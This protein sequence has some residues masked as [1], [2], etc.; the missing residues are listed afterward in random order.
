M[1]EKSES[2][3]SFSE[4]M[5]RMKR[6]V[7]QLVGGLDVQSVTRRLEEFGRANPTG[8]AVT[9]FAVGVAAGILMRKRMPQ[10]WASD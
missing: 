5:D 7:E 8:L 6:E 1:A 4:P 3:S 2:Q 10:D 9:A